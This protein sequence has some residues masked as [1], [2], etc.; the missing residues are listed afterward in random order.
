MI[1][2]LMKDPSNRSRTDMWFAWY[3]VRLGAL[4]TGSI[5]WL[6]RLRRSRC[7]GVTLY[8]RNPPHSPVEDPFDR[9]GREGLER[10]HSVLLKLAIERNVQKE[11]EKIFDPVVADQQFRIWLESRE[12]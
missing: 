1:D 10:L 11:F 5:S 8:W 12:Q 4:G 3:P 9:M 7:C 6:R 2:Q